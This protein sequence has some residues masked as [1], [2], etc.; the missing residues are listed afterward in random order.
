MGGFVLLVLIWLTRARLKLGY[1]TWQI[2]ALEKVDLLRGVAPDIIPPVKQPIL[3]KR[4]V[5][6]I[7]EFL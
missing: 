3:W 1:W 4:V 2:Q 5:H 6:E 7:L